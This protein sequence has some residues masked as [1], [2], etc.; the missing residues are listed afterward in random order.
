MGERRVIEGPKALALHRNEVIEAITDVHILKPNQALR[1]RCL[2]DKKIEIDGKEV[3]LKVCI[4][5][6]HLSNLYLLLN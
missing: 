5:S 1:L 2:V 6:N 3:D 4:L